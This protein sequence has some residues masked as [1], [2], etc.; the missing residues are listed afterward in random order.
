M[1]KKIVIA[2]A[3]VSIGAGIAATRDIAGAPA[4]AA[5]EAPLVSVA[6]VRQRDLPLLFTV[7]GHVTPLNQVEVRP[8]VTGIVKAVH[9][10]EGDRVAAGQLLFTL[11]ASDA[12]AL[13]D[14]A[15]AQAAQ[16]R[17]QLDDAQRGVKRSRSMVASGFIAPSALDTDTSKVE[18][19]Q[20]QL[21][22]AQ[23]DI[24]NARIQLDRTHIV[25]PIA[26]RTGAV[27]VHPGS[28]AQQNA[29]AALVSIV[30]PDPIAVE[31]ELPEQALAALRAAQAAGGASVR[32]EGR[33]GAGELTFINSAVNT[34]SGTVTI[35]ASFPNKD[36]GLWPGSFVRVALEAGKQKDATVLPPQAVLDGPQGRFVF[37]VGADSK[38]ERRPV[39]L[40]RVQD[41]LAMVSGVRD[42]ERVVVEGGQE[43]RPGARVRVK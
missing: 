39:E 31:F 33:D 13:L 20:A 42:G 37:V 27:E 21:A 14:R 5:K 12:T 24:D 36:Q 6:G 10:K 19:L 23:A 29:A 3:I 35:K 7:Q 18:G 8:Q 32:L 28:L 30:Q 4:S 9:F 25:A 34:A 26:G 22:A 2:A 41:Q 11:D 15:R 16:I 1:K 43:V 38:A 17:A 40:L